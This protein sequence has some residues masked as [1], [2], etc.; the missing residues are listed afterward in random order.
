MKK[1]NLF[2]I[3]FLILI[4]LGG[5]TIQA[6]EE[7]KESPFSVN[8]DLMSRYV[9]RGTDFGAS[10]SIQPGLSFN[11]WGLTVGAWGA[12]ATNLPGV[13]EADLY[14]SYNITDMFTLTFTDYFFPDEINGYKYFNYKEASTGHIFEGSISFNGTEKFPLSVLLATNFYGA[15]A[16]R[17]ND[18]GTTGNIQYSTYAE[19]SY[20]FKYFEAFMGFNLT[21]PDAD[22]GEAGFYGDSFGV[23]N[24]GV[25]AAKD[26]QITEKFSLPLTASLITNPQSEKIYLVVG[27]SF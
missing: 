7:A 5:N 21:T 26:I 8:V 4:V 11:K 27:F 3:L 22:K 14:L 15:D 24:L 1:H 16:R 17:L 6:Q 20:A 23:V 18:D 13:Q 12:Y 2:T 10:P 25:S 9:W 19:L